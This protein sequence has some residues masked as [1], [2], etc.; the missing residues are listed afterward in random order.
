MLFCN[1]CGKS[2]AEGTRFCP[3]CG[4][5]MASPEVPAQPQQAYVPPQ[6][7]TYA[8]PQPY[9]PPQ[10]TYEPPQPAYAG[11]SDYQSPDPEP[12]YSAPEPP[13]KKKPNKLLVI[14]API[15]AVVLIAAGVLA[16]ILFR[17]TPLVAATRALSNLDAEIT[18]RIDTTPLKA[19]TM[20][21]DLMEDGSIRAEFTYSDMYTDEYKGNIKLNSNTTDRDFGVEF[22]LSAGRDSLDFEAFINKERLAVGS[23]LLDNN[24]YGFKYG[25]FRRDVRS[26]GEL[27]G[28]D[29]KTMND[30]ADIIDMVNE[31]MNMEEAD[32]K[33]REV[34]SK[35]MTKFFNS[36]EITSEREKIDSGGSSVNSTKIEIAFTE[37]ALFTMLNDYIELFE[38]ED[39]L[40]QYTK[41]LDKDFLRDGFMDLNNEYNR[42][43]KELKD[44]LRDFERRLSGDISITMFVGSRNRLLR[45]EINA[46]M[47]Y[48]KERVRIKATFDFGASAQ[49]RWTVNLSVSLDNDRI[50]F[51][52]VWDYRERSNSIE[53][54]ITL[55]PDNGEPLVLKSTWSP[56]RGN[57]TLSYNDGWNEN[58]LSGVFTTSD[59][60]FRLSFDNLWDANTNYLERVLKLDIRAETGAQSKRVDFINIDRW[61][62]VFLERIGGMME[63][64][65]VGGVTEVVPSFPGISLSEYGG[66]I[67]IMRDTEL[68][69]TPAESGHWIFMTYDNGDS[70]PYLELFDSYGSHIDSDDDSG[71]DF[72][73][74]MIVYLDAG[75]TYTIYAGFYGE[76]GSYTLAV[77][78]S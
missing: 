36:C 62:E 29:D 60:G 61:D 65:G 72:N 41:I 34:Y 19:L 46:D 23:S 15:L 42:A 31:L 27:I 54:T 63:N 47:R 35:P 5:P 64:F 39:V 2:V 49:D 33:Q 53:N 38:D 22:N 3:G 25:T 77:A 10:Q 73:A 48:E 45:A 57:F 14:G 58:E 17:A 1:K 69:F 50:S 70:D 13:P 66:E 68:T 44:Q 7:P 20:L 9:V 74:F 43:M 30:L 59:K 78:R 56:D 12:G 28:L 26:F 8:P 24:Y 51:K 76:P 16:F 67:R 75:Y 32:A 71:G 11:Y 55:T 37:E 52:G 6:E 4:N 40:T 18:E 21:P